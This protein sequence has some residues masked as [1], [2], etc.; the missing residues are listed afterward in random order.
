MWCVV[1]VRIFF[2]VIWY[3]INSYS[4]LEKNYVLLVFIYLAISTELDTQLAHDKWLLT[5]NLWGLRGE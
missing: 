2:Q 4:L 1:I 5:W 3:E